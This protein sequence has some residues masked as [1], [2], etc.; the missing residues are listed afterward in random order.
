MPDHTAERPGGGPLAAAAY[1]ALTELERVNELAANAPGLAERRALADTAAWRYELYQVALARLGG[2]EPVEAMAP[3]AAA[4]DDARRRLRTADWWEGL[5]AS[6]LG[7]ALSDDLFG[8]LATRDAAPD[9]AAQAA[10]AAEPAEPTWVQLRLSEAVREDPALAARLSLWSRRVV[11]EA[12][13]LAR[14]FGGEGYPELAA[15]LAANHE[16][17]MAAL[18]LQG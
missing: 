4:L 16:N 10:G 8:A 15:R 12:I 5:A 6:S 3:A 13:V 14:E 18:G 11:G 2:A 1:A 17:R 9:G 7:G